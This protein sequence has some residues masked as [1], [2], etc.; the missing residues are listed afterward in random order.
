M[1][2]IHEIHPKVKSKSG[3]RVGRGGKRGTF[4]GRGTKGQKARAG[5]K[6]R[7][8][9]RD[10]LKKIPKKRGY[11]F[12]SFREKAA[13]VNIG[14]LADKFKSGDIITPEKLFKA[15]LVR[16]NKGRLPKIKI[17]GGGKLKKKLSFKNVLMSD[18]VKK[19]LSLT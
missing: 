13:I 10:I 9:L 2:Q 6:I 5:H 4:S 8:Q 15:G 11:R 17:L 3:K 18:K 12:S 16:K 1:A 19:E 7:P 14:D